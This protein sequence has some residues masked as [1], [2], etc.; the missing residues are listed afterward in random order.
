MTY[1]PIDPDVK[2]DHSI[3][4]TN[5]LD[6]G[7][8]IVGNPTWTIYPV[9]PTLSDTSIVG[10]IATVFVAGC[11]VGVVY[12]LTCHIVTDAAVAQTQERSIELRCDHR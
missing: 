12:K 8:N 9:G 2:I 5:W 3:N 1:R 6:P 11:V 7:V 10:N 4:W